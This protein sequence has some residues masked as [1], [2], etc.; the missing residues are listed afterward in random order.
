MRDEDAEKR[1]LIGKHHVEFLIQVP[2]ICF[3]KVVLVSREKEAQANTAVDDHDC[4]RDQTPRFLISKQ[5]QV[6]RVA[7]VQE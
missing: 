2:V 1:Q 4:C 7:C 5:K 6:E 3:I